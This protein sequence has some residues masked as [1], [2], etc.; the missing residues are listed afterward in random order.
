MIGFTGTEL[1]A[2]L[3]AW[4]LP[5]ARIAALFSSAPLLSHAAFPPQL[6]LACA[7]AITASVASVT[8]GYA[9]PS[10]TAMI[11]ALIEQVAVGLAVGFTLQLVF[12]AAT[13]AGEVIGLQMGIGFATFFDPSGN[14][15]SPLPATLLTLVAFLLFLSTDTHLV[16]IGAVAEHFRELPPGT[17]VSALDPAVIV[18]AGESVF[19][20]GLQLAIAPIVGLL[21]VNLAF[22]FVAR[23][24][25][26]LNIF[27]VGFPATLLAGIALL[28]ISAPAWVRALQAALTE[29]VAAI[30]R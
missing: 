23:V 30:G 16:L 6:R 19:R 15:E 5:F 8:P 10:G 7:I 20:L 18:R 21:M 26:Q 24:S 1:Q 25:P 2:L 4:L 14:G 27:S 28:A 11:L 22:G 9:P 29:T 12:A 17:L 3:A 13:L